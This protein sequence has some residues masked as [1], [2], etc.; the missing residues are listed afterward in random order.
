MTDNEYLKNI[1][2]L[3]GALLSK[4]DDTLRNV[5]GVLIFIAAVLIFILVGVWVS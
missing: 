4:I 3:H 1:E 5:V 2:T